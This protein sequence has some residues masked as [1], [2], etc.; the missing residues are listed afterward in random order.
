[1]TGVVNDV[2]LP[3]AGD[4]LGFINGCMLL[5]RFYSVF[6]IGKHRWTRKLLRS[7][8]WRA[9]D[10][11]WLE[12]VAAFGLGLWFEVEF[13]LTDGLLFKHN[14]PPRCYIPSVFGYLVAPWQIIL[15]I[16]WYCAQDCASC[17]RRVGTD[18]GSS[19]GH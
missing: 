11:R 16:S 12:V 15:T 7:L 18:K 14:W 2:G 9:I 10:H 1:V 5:E 6:D 4:G 3:L 19:F 8:R 17:A 13:V